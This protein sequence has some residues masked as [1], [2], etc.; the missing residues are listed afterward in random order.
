MENNANSV[1]DTVVNVDNTN[2]QEINKGTQENENST[3]AT[4]ENVVQ[5]V[6]YKKKFSESS[7]EA[8]RLFKENEELKKS[9]MLKD[10]VHENVQN[11]DSF[12][13]GFED[14]DEDAKNNLIAYTNTVTN[15]AKEELYKDPAIAFARTQY[16]EQIWES[17]FN[18]T[19][20]KY[21]DLANS[22]D[23]F[24]S[25]YFNPNNVPQNIN[26]ILEDVAK[27]HL[28][29]KAKEIGVKEA[30]EKKNL[31]DIERATSGE[32][33]STV[34]RSLGD[35]QRM[36]QENPGKFASL[37]KEYQSDLASGKI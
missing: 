35:W 23:E 28:F 22:K 7:S 19:V 15:K 25:R 36:A 21:P 13:P 20:S 37:S 27:I 30:E 26:S 4:I 5:T 8:Q 6:D 29:D 33:K 2:S 32:N 10:N 12:Y 3:N 14:L 18:Q 24:K 1:V 34:T 9:L 11:T 31:D 17:A 16:N